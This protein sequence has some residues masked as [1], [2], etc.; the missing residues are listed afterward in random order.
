MRQINLTILP[1][2]TVIKAS[3]LWT[4]YKYVCKINLTTLPVTTVISF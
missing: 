4:M 1:V 2:I 3:T